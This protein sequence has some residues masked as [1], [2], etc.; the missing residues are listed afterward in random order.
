MDKDGQTIDFRLTE[1]RD[2]EAAL[3]CLTQAS[4][5]NGGPETITL[6]GSDANEAALKS[7]NQEHGTAIVMRQVKD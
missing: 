6:D 5:R 4:R 7:Y 2:T 3:R 1:H